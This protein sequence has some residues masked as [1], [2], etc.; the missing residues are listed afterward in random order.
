MNAGPPVW[1]D[2]ELLIISRS[3]LTG[4]PESI[5]P[6]TTYVSLYDPANDAWRT[7]G[8]QEVY[9]PTG[10]DAWAGE[11]LITGDAAY[12]P[13][14]DEWLALPSRPPREGYTPVWTGDELLVW[15]GSAAGESM[16]HELNGFAYRPD[17]R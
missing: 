1:I 4:Q 13:A 12:D 5:P 17:D 11:L 7:A 2:G 10:G 6:D 8:A 15:G 3:L 16:V 9:L 14:A